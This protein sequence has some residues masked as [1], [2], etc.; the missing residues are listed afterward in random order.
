MKT[1]LLSSAGL[2]FFLGLVLIPSAYALPVQYNQTALNFGLT[3]VPRNSSSYDVF[4]LIPDN[5]L[6]MKFNNDTTDYSPLN[7][8]SSITYNSNLVGLY[9]FENNVFDSTTNANNGAVTGTTTYVSGQ[10]GNAFSFNGN[11]RITISNTPIKFERTQPFSIS[12]WMNPSSATGEIFTDNGCI[13]GCSSGW[14]LSM[15][16][17]TQ[18]YFELA[19]SP[20]NTNLIRV[21]NTNS[22][23]SGWH[24]F[25]ITYAGDSNA[26]NIKYYVDGVSVSVAVDVNN[27]STSIIPA[28]ASAYIGARS[29][30]SIGLTG[31]LDELRIYNIQLSSTQASALYMVGHYSQSHTFDGGEYVQTTTNTP[32]NFE[33]NQP[34]SGGG[35]IFPTDNAAGTEYIFDHRSVTVGWGFF[36][37]GTYLDF[38]MV[39]NN[40]AEIKATYTLPQNTWSYVFFTYDGSGTLGG[41]KIYVNGLSQTVTLTGSFPTTTIQNNGN[42]FIGSRFSAANFM[43]GQFDNLKIYPYSLSTSEVASDYNSISP[44][45]SGKQFMS[46]YNGISGSST[47]T[48]KLGFGPSTTTLLCSLNTITPTIVSNMSNIYYECGNTVKKFD[49]VQ[50]T[51]THVYTS[52]DASG[53][54]ERS[55]FQGIKHIFSASADPASGFN[56]Q[57]NSE[58]GNVTQGGSTV[59]SHWFTSNQEIIVDSTNS[60]IKFNDNSTT[61]RP[62]SILNKC[63]INFNPTNTTKALDSI[64][65]DQAVP[66]MAIKYWNG[67]MIQKIG[68]YNTNT[69]QTFLNSIDASAYKKLLTLPC[70]LYGAEAP[71]ITFI[72]TDQTQTDYLVVLTSAHVY[73]GNAQTALTKLQ[74]NNYALQSYD[75]ITVNTDSTFPI[76]N[77]ILQDM[78]L[79]GFNLN[80]T[81]HKTGLMTLPSGYSLRTTTVSPSIRLIDP[82]WSSDNTDI[83]IISSTSSLFPIFLTVTNAPQFSAIKVTQGNQILNGQEAVWSIAQLDSTRSVEFDLPSGTCANTYIAD[84]SVS[85]SIWNFEGIIC[86]SGLNQKT[87]SYTNTLPFTFWTYP[88]GASDSFT[89]NTNGLVTT[90]RHTTAPFSYN[91]VLKN[92]TGN[93]FQNT[94]YTSNSTIDTQN[95]NL[96]GRAKPVSLYIS[97]V[98]GGVNQIYSAFLGSP[99]SLAS[100]ASFFNQ[101]F[102]YQGFNLLAFIPIVFASMFTRN[103][104]GIGVVLTVLCI[105]TLSWLSVVVIPELDI[106]IMIVIA[107]IGLI[108][109]RLTYY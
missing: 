3:S 78:T 8:G 83:P 22:F 36:N 50:N 20:P 5:W 49:I 34:F 72:L 33:Y 27:L 56:Y 53:V 48:K 62:L 94:T 28:G 40:V 58:K 65:C 45:S 29:D 19:G 92:S 46:Y 81:I 76:P 87:I 17:S 57:L 86:A 59:N 14:G 4:P 106:M 102:S 91:I 97:S 71:C 63:N 98:T 104:I 61:I 109:Y 96:T 70:A 16:S 11:T 18:F 84:I 1:L 108:A 89:P 51:N 44:I 32:A 35:W 101:Y 100:T 25:V 2:I 103:T 95:F 60:G 10:E 26:N 90:V 82:R 37:G 43:V 68:G 77:P 15:L 52:T 55:L 75:V 99:I 79:Y 21:H 73:Y 12:F 80:T 41:V 38:F 105:A 24:H 64:A 31:K 6:W 74:N 47:L 54:T 88:W 93:V 23:T 42:L 30:S 69:T 66:A 9:K 39:G 7:V 107:I 13:L 85:P 67:M